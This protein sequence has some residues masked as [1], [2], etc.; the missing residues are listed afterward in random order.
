[1]ALFASLI[2][3]QLRKPDKAPEKKLWDTISQKIPPA[4][5]EPVWLLLSNCSCA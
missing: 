5:T 1:M 3:L 4:G 2:W